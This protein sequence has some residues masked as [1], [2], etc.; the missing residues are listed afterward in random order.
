MPVP[1]NNN[2]ANA[3]TLSGNS[4]SI[5]GSNISASAEVGEPANNGRT[6]WYGFTPSIRSCW[7][8]QTSYNPHI[9]ISASTPVL[10]SYL[11]VF[12]GSGGV[13]AISELPLYTGTL[14]END[15]PNTYLSSWTWKQRYANWDIGSFI[16]F[17][18][19]IDGGSSAEGPPNTT[20]YIRV[21]G[22]IDPISGSVGQGNFV[23]S[24]N[25]FIPPVYGNCNGCPP[26]FDAGFK[27]LTSVQ[28]TYT[29]FTSSVT[30][31]LGTF[32]TGH[33]VMSYAGGAM[34]SADV[35]QFFPNNPYWLASDCGD[36]FVGVTFQSGS[37][38]INMPFC[39]NLPDYPYFFWNEGQV[40][41]AN[42]CGNY[43]FTHT[44]GEIDF[45]T[46]DVDGDLNI[47][48]G[49]DDIVGSR[50]PTWCLYQII[51]NFSISTACVNWNTPGVSANGVFTIQNNSY[52]TWTKDDNIT[53]SILNS[54][55]I[56]GGNV[57]TQSVFSGSTSTDLSFNFN[58]NTENVIATLQFS[59]PMFPTF[60]LPCVLNP[61][62]VASGV[63]FIFNQQ[64]NATV[65]EILQLF[66][67]SNRGY[68]SFRP[69]ITCSLSSLSFLSNCLPTSSIVTGDDGGG[70]LFCNNATSALILIPLIDPSVT[71][72]VILTGLVHSLDSG[73]FLN[74]ITVPMTVTPW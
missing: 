20:Y 17:N 40:T 15:L 11:Q 73:A 14:V 27:C 16:V 26:K 53:I 71:T 5:S 58:C 62:A 45:F 39:N 59:S 64:C 30:Q 9:S 63:E 67:L 48:P 31:S 69:Q 12:T 25:Q 44:G 10:M 46:Q 50:P 36:T 21:D 49:Q 47:N 18:G 70:I 56:S 61:I 23:L 34:G 38:R 52:S 8:F 57:L 2:F 74:T 66:G 24:W 54:G 3:I 43:S 28:N 42:V 7:L 35:H 37:K 13:A 32:P 6:V 33:Y 60:T 4:G 65:K 51:P 72:N 22:A 1:P 29:Y 19:Q 55:G 41:M 68:F